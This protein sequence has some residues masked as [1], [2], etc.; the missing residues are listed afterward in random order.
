LLNAR[1]VDLCTAASA[2]GLRQFW[3]SFGCWLVLSMIFSHL[4]F[5]GDWIDPFESLF[6]HLLTWDFL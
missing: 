2:G 4:L 6:A 1:N 5:P 3:V